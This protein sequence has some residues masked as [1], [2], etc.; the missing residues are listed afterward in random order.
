MATT[1]RPDLAALMPR[2]NPYTVPWLAN[3]IKV[4]TTAAYIFPQKYGTGTVQSGRNLS[5][6]P[7]AEDFATN[8]TA[9]AL[10]E[11]IDRQ[12][13]DDRILAQYGG[14]AG[15]QVGMATR[16]HLAVQKALEQLFAEQVLDGGA[17]VPGTASTNWIADLKNAAFAVGD[18]V[19]GRI[20][21]VC[22]QSLYL[23]LVNDSGVIGEMAKQPT[24][25]AT[26]SDPNSVRMV[27]R[28]L[29]AA[30]I[31]VDEVIVGG[32]DVWDAVS[33][34][35]D[36]CVAVM[37]LPSAGMDAQEEIQALAYVQQVIGGEG[38][39]FG[40]SSHYSDDKKAN[41]VDV[42]TNALV[43]VVNADLIQLVKLS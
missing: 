34:T 15:A 11:V 9:V 16:A 35:N 25:L 26:S 4:A 10:T 18:L 43:D 20:G 23:N 1:P 12:T 33:I 13:L 6:A 30:A 29:L 2:R 28:Q 21:L 19:N 31:G 37:A 14:L 38:N 22:G 7:T 32:T 24:V 40:A 41:V 5:A 36:T 3:P 42:W 17:T 27:R 8:A 39:F